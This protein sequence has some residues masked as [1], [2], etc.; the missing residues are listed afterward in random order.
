MLKDWKFCAREFGRALSRYD[1]HS[2]YAKLE[3]ILSVPTNP[4]FDDNPSCYAAQLISEV[5]ALDVSRRAAFEHLRHGISLGFLERIISGGA[6]FKPGSGIV[7][8]IDET[9]RIALTPL[10]RTLRAADRLQLHKFRDFVI[11]TALLD[12]DF[13]MYG[14]LLKVAGDNHENIVNLTDFKGYLRDI[15]QQRKEWLDRHVPTRPVKEQINSYVAWRNHQISDT[16]IK[17]HFNM[18]RQW[19][20]ELSHIGKI[21]KTT[22]AL[23]DTGKQLACQITAV[24]SRNSLFWLAPSHECVMKLGIVSKPTESVFS[25]WDLFRLDLP[26]TPPR[27]EMIREVA[28][29]MKESFDIVRLRAFAQAPIA[30]IIPYIHFQEVCR[31]ER[32]DLSTTL[33]AIIRDYRDRF[34][35]ML[36]ATPEECYY[37]L[38]THPAKV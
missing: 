7:S 14:L 3:Y 37:Q 15:L 8:K 38:R 10:A 19:A 23:T 18:R 6:I 16:S 22:D 20:K 34:Y 11:A 30:S 31:N 36:T 17:H 24:A 9:A 32:V 12:Y 13:D 2:T 4:L 29:F 1:G 28:E 25:A 21:D 26:E 27:S 33:K 35:C 5:E